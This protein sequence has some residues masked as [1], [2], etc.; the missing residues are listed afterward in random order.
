MKTR[1]CIDTVLLQKLAILVLG[2]TLALTLAAVA[3]A[4]NLP[5]YQPRSLIEAEHALAEGQPGHALSHLHRGRAVLRD[6]RFRLQREAI[7]C[8]A[9]I[10]L[11][12][13]EQAA[14]VCSDAVAYEVGTADRPAHDR[15]SD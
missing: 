11:Q 14:R 4:E 7:A 3:R 2:L 10:Q 13:F 1:Q 15:A 6:E 12:A 8:R 5:D 9:H